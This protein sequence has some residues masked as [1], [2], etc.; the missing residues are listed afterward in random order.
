[1]G[2]REIY[3]D[4]I[5]DTLLSLSTKLKSSTRLNL[6]NGNIFA[7]PFFGQFLNFLFDWH[8]EST[9]NSRANYA[10]VDLIDDE[11]HILVQVTSRTDKRKIQGTLDKSNLQNFKGYQ[12]WFVIIA[13]SADKLQKASYT[14]KTEVAFEPK[15]GIL[16]IN[17]LLARC[18]DAKT[19][20]LLNLYTLCQKEYGIGVQRPF[21]MSP[22]V[23]LLSII[24]KAEGDLEPDFRFPKS[25]DIQK[26]IDF[27]RLNELEAQTIS[28][29]QLY[30]P[31][32]TE[33]YD[34]FDREGVGSRIIFQKLIS[35]YQNQ[36]IRYPEKVNPIIFLDMVND[37]MT[38]IDQNQGQNALPSLEEQEYYCRV[39]LVDAFIRYKIF[40]NPE[41][42]IYDLAK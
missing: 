2:T 10:A 34:V 26:K 7:E 36:K 33:I 30:Y 19:D 29:M 11:R 21:T 8:L 42:Y 41:G 32:L 12:L 38:Y 18:R 20:V 28:E 22:L 15:E 24:A 4:Y 39:I 35:L 31:Q 6:A 5:Q 23:E 13:E 27:N 17:T 3:F 1:M 40:E 37:L 16:S 9:N 25:F 14:N